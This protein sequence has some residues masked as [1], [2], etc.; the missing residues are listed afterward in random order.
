MLKNNFEKNLQL[1]DSNSEVQKTGKLLVLKL[2]K[3]LLTLIFLI[4]ILMGLVIFPCISTLVNQA[5]QSLH[6]GRHLKLRLQSL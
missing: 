2:L 6:G 5:L 1:K 3:G 4:I